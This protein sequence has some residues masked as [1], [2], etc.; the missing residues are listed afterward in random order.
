MQTWE[1]SGASSPGCGAPMRSLLLCRSSLVP[2][3]FRS[4]LSCQAA[5]AAPLFFSSRRRHTRLQGDWSFRRVLFRSIDAA[6]VLR[7]IGIPAPV[8]FLFQ[9]KEIVVLQT[10]SRRQSA[11][12]TADDHHVMPR[13]GWGPLEYLIAL[14]AHLMADSVFLAV[15]I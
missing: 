15:H 5:A 13:R 3:S 6:L 1:R 4:A 2:R 10:I 11:H 14:I 9:Q 8:R 7:G 12:A